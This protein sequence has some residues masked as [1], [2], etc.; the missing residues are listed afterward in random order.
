MLLDRDS[1]IHFAR[2]YELARAKVIPNPCPSARSIPL[3]RRETNPPNPARE[4]SPCFQTIGRLSTQP[5]HAMPEFQCFRDSPCCAMP[6]HASCLF[7]VA[8]LIPTL[9]QICLS[10][11]RVQYGMKRNN[12]VDAVYCNG[13]PCRNDP[14][15]TLSKAQVVQI[16]YES[17]I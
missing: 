16:F 8:Y 4:R 7:Q 17:E 14:R 1:S 11:C 9:L 13:K 12:G 10:F 6:L 3:A 2:T 15:F 5:C